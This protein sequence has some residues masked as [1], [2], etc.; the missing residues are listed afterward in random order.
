MYPSN[1]HEESRLI[2]TAIVL[3]FIAV[4]ASIAVAEQSAE[5]RSA[6]KAG[7]PVTLASNGD[8]QTEVS[9]AVEVPLVLELDVPASGL[10]IELQAGEDLILS[11]ERAVTEAPNPRR[12]R[13]DLG[14]VRATPVASGRHYLG[15]TVF[16][17][18][19]ERGFR[20][21]SIPIHA[22]KSTLTPGR[23]RADVVVDED[24]RVLR[25][26]P[27]RTSR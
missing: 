4:S 13:L 17:D 27:A 3:G 1:P 19:V 7:A 6:G 15:V 8:Y 22:G 5:W 9:V 12:G 14:V 26:M 18:G 23:K 20:S 24:G 21:F 25:I 10:R 16:L 2:R 11:A